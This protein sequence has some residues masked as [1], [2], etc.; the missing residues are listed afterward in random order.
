MDVTD[1]VD[2]VGGDGHA[3][4]G[5]FERGNLCFPESGELAVCV[6]L[7]SP[8]GDLD[9]VEGHSWIAEDLAPPFDEVFHFTRV[10]EAV[11][12][13]DVGFALIPNRSF[14]REVGDG[15]DHAIV[16]F[17]GPF[18]GDD[19]GFDGRAAPGTIDE[20]HGD[21]GF[22]VNV[23]S[24]VVEDGRE[25]WD[26]LG[27][28]VFPG[29]LDVGLRGIL[30]NL[31]N[32]E[33]ADL[34]VLGLLNEFLFLFG[35]GEVPFHVGLAGSDPDI[36]DEDVGKGELVVSLDGK[37]VGFVVELWS[38]KFG[39]PGSVRRGFGGGFFTVE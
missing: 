5:K 23:F 11:F 14:D 39:E 2:D 19:P 25:A 18:A 16:H 36:A 30:L 38:G 28:A 13:D 12:L 32:V 3:G 34:G 29:R 35:L 17:S 9:I 20:T 33:E 26:V 4:V 8:G 31:G 7:V 10:S 6:S 21:F 37:F 1:V 15:G 24:E 22:L 27:R